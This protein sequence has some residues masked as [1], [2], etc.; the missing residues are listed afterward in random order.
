MAQDADK[1]ML[2]SL[3]GLASV[4]EVRD[5]YTGG[6]LWRVGQFSR[7]LAESI[8]M[9]DRQVFLV[10]IGGILHDLGKIGVPDAILRKP[11]KL[12]DDEYAVIK[13]HPAM[14]RDLLSS[15]PLAELAE[16]AVYRHHEHMAGGGY[17]DG[18]HGEEIPLVARI[19]G[20]TD[21]FDAMTSSR[22][23]RK[24][25][26]IEKALTILEAEAG[27]QFDATLVSRFA[28]LHRTHGRL[29]S[30]VGHS[31]HGN[32]MAVCPGC[33]PVIALPRHFQNGQVAVCRC[34]G[35][36]FTMH[37]AG[38]GFA[39]ELVGAATS[40]ELRPQPEYHPLEEFVAMAPKPRSLFGFR[41]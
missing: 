29:A 4:V 28:E 31:D 22:P 20:L 3:V 35:G 13:T 30:V 27:R 12:T 16:D 18:L 25:M 10:A 2:R 7:M 41:F 6:H 37:K 36:K 8:G 11:D 26:P 19:V 40:D 39:A 32:P 24:G 14:G 23:Y 21:A 17:P 5:P 9:E 33:G 38:D 15:H 34:C 1:G